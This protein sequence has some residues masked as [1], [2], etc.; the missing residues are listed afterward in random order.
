MNFEK[1]FYG[2]QEIIQD[3]RK[4]KFEYFL[5]RRFEGVN[6]FYGIGVNQKINSFNSDY[7]QI[8]DISDSYSKIR[9]ILYEV[10]DNRV[11]PVN[12][13]YIVDELYE[14]PEIEEIKLIYKA[15]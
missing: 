14:E 8:D 12:L 1:F 11:S 2:D 7:Q 10:M 9:R 5:I 6:V 4:I 15:S 13:T 3:G